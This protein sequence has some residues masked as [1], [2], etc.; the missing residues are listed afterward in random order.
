MNPIDRVFDEFAQAWTAGRR[1]DVHDYLNRVSG[2]DEREEL[3]QRLHEWLTIAP[4]PAYDEATLAKLSAD[5]ALRHAFAAGDAA[6][7]EPLGARLRRL[8]EQAGLEIRDVA[9]RLV[10]LFEGADEQRA[11]DYLAKVERKKLDESRLSNRLLDGLASI[12]RTDPATLAPRAPE[13]LLAQ[14][15]F[16]AD[17]E[18]QH[19]MRDDLAVLAALVRAP[20]PEPMDETDRLF[21]GGPDA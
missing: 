18:G 6:E 21:R 19:A 5:P 7:A 12:L 14:A 2:D 9:A 13:P 3:A 4:T 17:D 10:A 16:R 11:A 15:F 8:R 20:A 1:P